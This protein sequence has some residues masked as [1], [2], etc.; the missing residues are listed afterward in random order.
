M[1][2]VI[3]HGYTSDYHD[4]YVYL[5][6]KKDIEL[7]PKEL[8]ERFKKLTYSFSFE[9]NQERKLERVDASNVINSLSEKG[10][11][12]RIDSPETEDLLNKYRKDQGLPPI[13]NERLNNPGE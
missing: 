5:K 13:V 6:D 10:Y 3:Y 12:I 8:L 2:C 4:V 7:I 11:Y 9:L 1:E